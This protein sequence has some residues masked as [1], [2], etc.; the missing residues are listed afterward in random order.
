MMSEVFSSLGDQ[1]NTTLQYMYLR[2]MMGN[3]Q[4]MHNHEQLFKLLPLVALTRIR[5]PSSG[6]Y[7]YTRK[8]ELCFVPVILDSLSSSF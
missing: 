2:G 4:Q 5:T 6:M 7:L 3:C 1:T 8:G